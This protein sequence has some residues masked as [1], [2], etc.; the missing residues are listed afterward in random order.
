M[1]FFDLYF[2][3]QLLC[4]HNDWYVKLYGILCRWVLWLFLLITFILF[5]LL[6]FKKQSDRQQMYLYLCYCIQYKVIH[7]YFKMLSIAHWSTFPMLIMMT[8]TVYELMLAMKYIKVL[9]HCK[10]FMVGLLDESKRHQEKSLKKCFLASQVCACVR[11]R[12]Y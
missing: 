6:R 5:E 7:S 4:Y 10:C 2:L 1:I 11:A 3:L 12:T 9:S 8:C